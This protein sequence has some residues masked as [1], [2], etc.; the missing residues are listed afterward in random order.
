[1]NYADM[2]RALEREEI[3]ERHESVGDEEF[4]IVS[5]M[6]ATPDL[7]DVPNA[8]EA[9]GITF[10]ASG[11]CVCRTM[12][13]FFN[14]NE[15]KYTQM[16]NLD[17]TGAV[18]FDKLD[19]SM[20]TPVRLKDG[21]IRLKTKKSFYSDVALQAQQFFDTQDNLIAFVNHMLDNG[22]TPT[23]EFESPSSQI[24][25]EQTQ[26]KITLLLARHIKTGQDIS[27]D[28]LKGIA[29]HYN[30]PIVNAYPVDDIQDY[31]ARAEVEEGYEGWVFLLANGQRVKKKTKWYLAR[32][33]LTSY[34][35]RNIFDLIL[36]EEIDDLMPIFEQKEGA[37]DIVNDIGHRVAHLF[38]ETADAAESLVAEWVSRGLSLSDIGKNY[39]THKY[40]HLAIKLFKNQDPGFKAF[41]AKNYRSEF[42]TRSIFWG[43]DV[44]A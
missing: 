25:V 41:I 4:T 35:E 5:Y 15:N 32:H 21:S 16:A 27:Y 7:W 37:V 3:R 14:I 24:I 33:R 17:F 43:F 44:D 20:I 2:K 22:I 10:D 13:K 42:H 39:P 30:V 9:R 40:F 31:M 26:D 29:E 28:S 6:V 19:G 36:N 18:A 38:K 12:P 8:V 1:M 34:S 11:S 23:F